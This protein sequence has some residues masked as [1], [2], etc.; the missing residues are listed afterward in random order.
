MKKRLLSVILA[1]AMILTLTACADDSSSDGQGEKIKEAA[2]SA[3]TAESSE[4]TSAQETESEDMS[5]WTS[6]SETEDASES[7]EDTD[8]IQLIEAGCVNDGEHVISDAMYMNKLITLYSDK[9]YNIAQFGY[10]AVAAEWDTF[11]EG[12]YTLYSPDSD[13]QTGIDA[14]TYDIVPIEGES[15]YYYLEPEGADESDWTLLIDTQMQDG[16]AA[17]DLYNEQ[18][19]NIT[20]SNED[21][22]YTTYAYAYAD[23]DNDGTYS[24]GIDDVVWIASDQVER[25][26]LYGVDPD[27]VMDDYALIDNYDDKYDYTIYDGSTECSWLDDSQK[28]KSGS[29]SDFYKALSKKDKMLVKVTTLGEGLSSI[30]EEYVP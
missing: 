4:E 7:A 1:T 29:V 9:K 13:E 6:A 23:G 25:L 27:S 14:P 5:E 11:S 22:S 15:G 3:E 28:S 26:A 19:G 12:E 24:I 10:D 18:M 17:L 2:S 16:N 21:T 8:T 20:G 30:S